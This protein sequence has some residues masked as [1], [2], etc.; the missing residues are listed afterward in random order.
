MVAQVELPGRGVPVLG[1]PDVLVCGGGP[2]GFTA[3]VASARNG[4]STALLERYGFL[5]GMA[6]AGM[7]NP[8]Y[9]FFARH[10]QI[11]TGIPQELIDRLARIPGGTAGHMCRHDCVSRRAQYGECVTRRDE[12]GCPVAS[13]ANVCPVDGEAVKLAALQLVADAGVDYHLHTQI[14]EI[15]RRDHRIETVIVHGKSG[16]GAYRPKI[17]I[18]ATGDADVAAWAGVPFHQGNEE[19]GSVKPP[20]LMF[21][22]GNVKLTKDRILVRWPAQAVEEPGLRMTLPCWLMALPRPGEYTVNSPSGLSNFDPTQ[23]EHL[24]KGQA[25]TTRQVFQK[26]ELLRKYT[27]GCEEAVLL[28]IAP[29]LGLRDSRRIV[30]E[31][32]LTEDDVLASRKFDDGVVNGVHPIDLHVPSTRY[33]GRHLIPTPCGDYYQIPYR[34]LLPLGIENLLVA[35]RSISATFTAQGST[36]EMATCMAMGQAAGTA[37]ALAV[38]QPCAPSDANPTEIKR[39]LLAQGAYL[40]QENNI[41]ASNQGNAP[42]PPEYASPRAERIIDQRNAT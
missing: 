28:S 27:P 26:L 9:G 17:V 14:V 40:G 3:A 42:L 6:S 24:S 11:V 2:A 30:G 21:R 5:G 1:E 23:T 31:Y 37:A 12:K 35:G 36:R 41:P 16:Y 10:L 25:E 39:T 8:I 33:A 32:V 4:A 19:D 38:R 22:I 15:I 20:T 7:V 13:V 34:C 29:Q 18:D